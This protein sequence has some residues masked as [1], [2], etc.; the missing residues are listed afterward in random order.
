MKMQLTMLQKII[1][2]SNKITKFT[3]K[4]STVVTTTD[5]VFEA[6]LKFTPD[7]K[8]NSRLKSLSKTEDVWVKSPKG[9]QLKQVKTLKETMTLDGKPFSG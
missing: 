9:W 7:A 1:Q 3:V 6:D 8:K 4:G 5:G 2:I